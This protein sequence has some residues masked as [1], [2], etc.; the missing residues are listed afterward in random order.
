MDVLRIGELSTLTGVSRSTLRMWERRYGVVV[1]E[2][3]ENGYR[4]YSPEDIE[5]VLTMRRALS[6]GVGAS[7]A[8]AA[9]RAARDGGAEPSAYTAVA[10]LA[11][12]RSAFDAWDAARGSRAVQRAIVTLGVGVAAA[13][14]LL[15]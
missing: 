1:P 2:R 7:E 3:L 11:E 13:D 15:P 5:R 6:R 9:A 4:V 12:I 8:A 10:A 14:V